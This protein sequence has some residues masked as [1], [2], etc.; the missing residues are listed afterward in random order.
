MKHDTDSETAKIYDQKIRALSEEERFLRG[1]SLTQLCRQMTVA[2]IME[3]NKSFSPDEIK[4]ELRLLYHHPNNS[5][6]R[7]IL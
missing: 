2:G 3:R 4:R 7:M 6:A 1:L 5:F